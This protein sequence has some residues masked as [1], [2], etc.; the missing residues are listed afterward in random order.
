MAFEIFRDFDLTH[1]STFQTKAEAERFVRVEDVD[2]LRDALAYAK[3][4]N[5]P[6]TI[7][8]G[9]SNTIFLSKVPGLVVKL[10]LRGFLLTRDDET[11]DA[12]LEVGAGETLDDVIDALLDAGVGGLENLAAIPGTVG[13]AVVQNAGAYGLEMAER[14]ESVRVLRP[15]GSVVDYG[16]ADCDFGYRHSRF[17]TEAGKGEVILSAVLRFPKEWVARV[18]YKD[19]EAYRK[20]R[21]EPTT[22]Q[23]VAAAVRAVRAAKLPD[24]KEIGNAGSFFKNPVAEKLLWHHILTEHPGIPSYPLGGGRRKLAAAWLIE[25]AGWKGAERGSVG[26]Y[27]RHALI[28]VNL[29]GATGEDVLRVAEDIRS[30]VEDRFGLRLELEPVVVGEKT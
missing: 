7:L 16:V 14:I 10:G 22:P 13:G 17:K 6:V 29:G 9:G 24:P 11:G 28:L 23:T 1:S 8:G 15:D 5:L 30:D 2:E 18:D 21:L 19:L 26:V 3:E 27:K 25:A 4:E 20:T 12:L